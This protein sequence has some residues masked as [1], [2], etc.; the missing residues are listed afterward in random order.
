M[1]QSLHGFMGSAFDIR[2]F[3]KTIPF[4]ALEVVLKNTS[5]CVRSGCE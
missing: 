3:R 4:P 5:L 2:T 1:K